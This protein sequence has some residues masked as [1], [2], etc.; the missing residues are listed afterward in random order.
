M[1]AMHLVH[2]QAHLLGAGRGGTVLHLH[3]NRQRGWRP[4]L[5]AVRA[6]T[7]RAY[8]SLKA[9]LEGACRLSV[10]SALTS[11]GTSYLQVAANSPCQPCFD[12]TCRS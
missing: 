10:R 12:Q 11:A 4:Q 7:I 6:A 1:H 3:V 8:I 5:T 9:L 2:L